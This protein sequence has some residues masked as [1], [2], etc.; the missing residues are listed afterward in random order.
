MINKKV[1][2][3]LGMIFLIVFL[4]SNISAAEQSYC[5][6]KTKTSAWC[7]NSALD[8]CETSG[9]LR[10]APTSCESTSYC[11]IGTCY[12]KLEG[13]CM[14]NTPQRVCQESGGIWQQGQPENSPQCQLGCCLVGDQAAFVTQVRCNRL[15]SIYG[16]EINF[17]KDISNELNCIASATS[18]VKGACVFE[19]NYQRTCKFMTKRECSQTSEG[20]SSGEFHERYLCSAPDLNTT[21]GPSE[22]TICIDGKD[23]VYFTDTCGNLAN[24]YDSN[25]KTTKPD[26]WSKIY[27]KTK[28]CGYG[29]SNSN[30]N[31]CGN[32]DY[33]RGSTCKKSGVKNICKDLSCEW[34]GEKY[35]HGETWCAQSDGTSNII[36][37]EEAKTDAVKENLPGSRY[38][39]LVCYNSE[40]TI[41]P[42]A[43]FRQ[44]VCTQSELNEFATA[45]C[46]VNRWQDC[47]SQDNQKDCENE[48]RRDCQ[49]MKGVKLNQPNAG[50]SG[51]TS[52]ASSTMAFTQKN[53][54]ST[55]TGAV[56]SGE[57]NE[58]VMLSPSSKGSCVPKYS[59]GF[60]FWEA[61]SES[62]SV[63]SQAS[64]QCTVQWEEGLMGKP[65][66]V[67]G[68]ECIVAGWEAQMNKACVALGDC[69][70]KTN[71]IGVEG[72]NDEKAFYSKK[73]VEEKK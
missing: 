64:V 67:S 32:C 31:V 63:C 21:C 71:Y 9:G 4:I 6:E 30:S 38:F 43:D 5:C 12:D 62:D 19:K 65:T 15:S 60:N 22:K 46:R 57:N 55:I 20:N 61:N 28:S 53:T 72:Y 10:T 37:F 48:F 70:A 49:W 69:G 26:Y 24:I 42:C 45:V 25:W 13:T 59:P 18:D 50:A 41:E 17:R 34:K 11:K 7:I 35:Q 56:I 1:V 66:C 36:S 54:S 68:C 23:E 39:R 8:N 52:T 3:F 27:D 29:E 47:Y 44:E 33:Y 73:E 16:L 2:V 51:S 14:K 40:V 58:E